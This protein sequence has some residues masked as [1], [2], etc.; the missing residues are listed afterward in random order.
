MEIDT[1]NKYL[2]YLQNNT[3]DISD[4]NHLKTLK[5]L[6][7]SGV[8]IM[9]YVRLILKKSC[10]LGHLTVL[11]YLKT[12]H[13][14]FS[15]TKNLCPL[16]IACGEGHLSIVKFLANEGVDLC[17]NDGNPIHLAC[18]QDNHEIVKFLVKKGADF[19][20]KNLSDLQIACEQGDVSMINLYMICGLISNKHQKLIIETVNKT[21]QIGI[22]KYFV[23]NGYVMTDNVT[24]QSTLCET[25]IDV[26]SPKNIDNVITESITDNKKK[27][28]GLKRTLS[29]RIKNLF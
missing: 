18:I 25:K 4:I 10:Y 13:V 2:Y 28:N 29:K 5:F 11:K 26:K 6:V 23:N 16:E 12:E 21:G 19:T 8:N 27:S 9:N 14:D 3:S 15:C 24:T 1:I 7:N 17:C 22:L 20:H